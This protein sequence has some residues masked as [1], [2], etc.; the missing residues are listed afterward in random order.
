M[1]IESIKLK[2]FKAYKDIHLR[3]IPSFAVFIGANGTGK[4]TLF[5]VFSFL[6]D[7]LTYDVA[8]ALA[9]RGGFDEVLSRGSE[10]GII[11]IELQCR[12]E[13]ANVRRLVTYVLEIGKDA[14]QPYVKR[15][16]LR[17]KRQA[18]GAPFHFLDFVKGEG[19]A[20]SNEE[21][22]SKPDKELTREKQSLSR[23]NLL[24]IS[25]LG[26]LTRFKAAASLR[27]L[28]GNWHISDFHINAA[29]GVK[30]II[31]DAEHLSVDGDNLQLVAKNLKDYHP[32]IFNQIIECMKSC[33][34]G[35]SQIDTEVTIDGRLLLKFGD[36]SFKDPF[37]DKYVSDGTLKMFAYLVLLHDPRP[38]PFL[39]IEE[40]ENQ[41]YLSLLPNLADAFRDYAER[42][43][44]VF[45][46]T[47]SPDFLNSTT[48]DEVFWLVK[49]QG[50]TTIHRAKDD[51]QLCVYM[52]EGDQMGYLWS[53]GLFG[54]VN[55]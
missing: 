50:H 38:H 41:L 45:V 13:I 51:E 8:K 37:I 46:S 43:G 27:T 22:F 29:R 42:G 35:I 49:N 26:Q 55:P 10:E 7:C 48:V 23:R 36:G 14:G 39:C 28:I 34:P 4:S 40:P 1:R 32:E 2:N 24:A 16:I 5:D 17:Y 18:H 21:D 30:D 25:G 53:H 33:V 6:K 54:E 15:E 52:A 11:C 47:H 12:M 19:S 31:G 3:N 44:Q 9:K 20:I